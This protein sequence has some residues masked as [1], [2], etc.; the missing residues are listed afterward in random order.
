MGL[1]E[2]IGTLGS[3]ALRLY[4][5]VP[6][7]PHPRRVLPR[8]RPFPGRALVRRRGQDVLD[9]L[10]TGTDRLQRPQG[11]ALE[12]LGDPA[13]RLCPVPRRR[14]RGERAGPRRFGA[15]GAGRAGTLLRRQ[16]RRRACRHRRRR[17]DCQ[18]HPGDR[19]LHRDLQHLRPRG[20]DPAGRFG[21]A[22]TRRPR[23]PASS[24]AT[25]SS[26]STGPRSPASRTCSGWSASRAGSVLERRGA[27]RRPS[28]S[29][30]RSSRN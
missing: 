7:R 1:I 25:S 14:E 19:H 24:P 11:H 23:R 29:P 4:R 6:V 5:P 30:C 9:R 8:T 12:D 2:W 3:S 28:R 22:Q 18:F 17:P 13:R 27:A 21:G 10:R 16:G 15:D 20:D 26:R